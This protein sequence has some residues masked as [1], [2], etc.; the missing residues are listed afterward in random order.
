MQ[1][2]HPDEP[3]DGTKPRTLGRPTVQQIYGAAKAFDFDG[4]I[5]ITSS[6][7]SPD[8]KAF[9][10]LKPDE[11]KLYNREDIFQWITNYRWNTDEMA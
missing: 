2:K 9:S 3:T 5:A 1:C 7:Y 6:T 8:A 10:E 11:I 4:A